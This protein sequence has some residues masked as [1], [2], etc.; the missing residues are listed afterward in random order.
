VYEGEEVPMI[1]EREDETNVMVFRL[2]VE[3][4]PGQV[5]RL[6]LYYGHTE[7][8]ERPWGPSDVYHVWV[9]FLEAE[10]E[11]G[12]LETTRS[13]GG[14]VVRGSGSAEIPASGT[15]EGTFHLA[16]RL[17]FSQGAEG[18]M[19]ETRVE[20]APGDPDEDL[21]ARIRELVSR[22]G[23]E[24]WREREEAQRALVEIGRAAL[25]QLR[26]AARS[27]DPEV[28][29]RASAAI[30]EIEA[31]A[32]TNLSVRIWTS[33]GN[34][35]AQ[36]STGGTNPTVVTV[37]GRV[38]PPHSFS[39]TLVVRSI[40][41]GNG[42]QMQT[43]VGRQPAGLYNLTVPPQVSTTVAVR[44]GGAGELTLGWLKGYRTPPV[45]LQVEILAQ[46]SR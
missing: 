9:D 4:A 46:E 19:L 40:R 28:A 11:W 41:F 26:E 2:P 27:S 21:E 34:V 14:L 38:R 35:V 32:A 29:T 13:E 23:A 10:L 45:A 44:N 15:L 37:V 5:G 8:R 18:W 36:T 25:P 6:Y 42:F 24:D 17:G 31:R 1:V 33:G 22:L 30:A 16:L 39:D 43:Q 3:L 12:T 20:P 7:P